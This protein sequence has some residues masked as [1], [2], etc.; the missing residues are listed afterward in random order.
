MIRTR[1]V[2]GSYS[3]EQRNR[4]DQKSKQKKTDDK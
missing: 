1:I 3:P 4:D 2:A